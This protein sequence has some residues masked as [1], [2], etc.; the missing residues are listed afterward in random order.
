MDPSATGAGSAAEA[1]LTRFLIFEP[2]T[3]WEAS[4]SGI[5][6]GRGFKIVGYRDASG[7]DQADAHFYAGSTEPVECVPVS[8][9]A[10]KPRKHI[11]KIVQQATR[12][13]LAVNFAALPT[14]SPSTLEAR[15]APDVEDA[16]DSAPEDPAALEVD[17]LAVD[18]QD[19]DALADAEL[20]E[21]A[22]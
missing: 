1:K 17:G 9:N 12:E 16:D 4:Q 11:P 22:A 21:D 8:E 13:P 19:I 3:E 6:P 18:G 10:W 20:K 14:A 2:L 7:R 15:T 5:K